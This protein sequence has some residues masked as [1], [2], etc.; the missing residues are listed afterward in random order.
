MRP[1]VRAETHGR[2]IETE[3]P[4]TFEPSFFEGVDGRTYIPYTITVDGGRLD[5]PSA[6][7]YVC[8]VE[9]DASATTPPDV[10]GDGP[11]CVFEDVFSAAVTTTAGAQA[12]VSG[13][14][15][16]SAGAYDIYAAIRNDGAG[17]AGRGGGAGTRDRG[18]A[19]AATI[20]LA[21]E[22]LTV[23]D[24]GTPELRLSSVLVGDIQPL[25]A[26]LPPARQRLEPYTIG[27][28]RVVPRRRLSFS[29]QEELSFLYFV[30]GA[31]PPGAAKPDLTSEYRFH[32]ATVAGEQLFTWT[33]S[34]RH[35]AAAV[36]P[37]FDMRLGSPGGRRVGRCP[38][39]SLPVG[40][41][42]VSRSASRTTPSGAVAT[43]DVA[44]TVQPAA[45]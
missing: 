11:A 36:P 13:A 44:F 1:L 4:F 41:P 35:D 40:V 17:G 21:R 43:R 32:R 34:E 8:A 5:A 42:T 25:M 14:L 9:R 31:G 10:T 33:E 38:L 27:T 7:L 6:A 37:E 22:G 20:L 16:L 18:P 30:H 29:P 19:G 45:R 39:E 3:R 2:L 15:D 24:F 12:S 26:P 28:L 23:P